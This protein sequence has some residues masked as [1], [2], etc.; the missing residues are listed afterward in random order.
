MIKLITFTSL[1]AAM[2]SSTALASGAGSIDEI[3]L[4]SGGVAEISRKPLVSSDGLVEIEVPLGQVDD[5][6]KSL[7]LK[8]GRGVINNISLAGPSPL[9]EVFR[10]LPFTPSDLSSISSLLSSIPGTSVTVSSGGKTVKGKI[11]GI[12]NAAGT[13]DNKLYLLTVL[14]QDEK[15]QTIKLSEDT[16]LGIDDPDIKTKL[17]NATQAMGKGSNDSS[18]LIRIAA[19]D[20]GDEDARLAYVVAAPIWKAAYRVLTQPEGKARLQAW[21]VV[22]NASGEDWKD[23]KLT[24]TSADPVTLKQRLHQIYWK[25]R[26]EIPVNVATVNSVEADTGNLNNRIRSSSLS[27]KDTAFESDEPVM[28]AARAPAPATS[29]YGG[30]SA[31]EPLDGATATATENDISASFALPGTFNLANGDSLSVPI[32]DA[33]IDAEM[34]SI[35]RS[36]SSSAHPVAAL[37]LKNVTDTSMPGGILTVYDSRTGYVGD[38]ELIGLPKGD[39]RIAAFATDRKVTITQEQQPTRQIIDIKVVDGVVR[40]SEKLRETTTYRIS[41]ALDA[42]RTIV[43]EH[44]TRD[45]WSFSSDAED[46]R[47][48]SYRRLKTSVKAGQ[49]KAVVAVD[50]RI[51][52]ERYGLIDID[53]ATLVSWSSTASDKAVADKFAK[54]ADAQRVKAEKERELQNSEEKLQFLQDEQE[55]IRQ[56]IAAV[57]ENSDLKSKYLAMLDK[58][59]T[60]IADVSKKREADKAEIDH[61]AQL[62]RE[63]IRNF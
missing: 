14:D 58:S 49:E 33:Q 45:G 63:Q 61:L 4:S 48:L 55:R 34:I 40:I 8:G 37:M 20:L 42:D 21:A 9:D 22:E 11:L 23:V 43:I 25:D 19:S 26:V 17:A 52:D 7:V 47:T 3:T 28:E 56:N 10:Q 36:A 54:L 53:P 46:G 12:E 32:A 15:I 31:N 62:L 44:P 5:V 18:R 51:Q 16:S 60:T 1:V 38:A 50:E 27:K 6:L 57:P 30:S 2:L 24:L 35:Y 59:E 41:G 29:G 39:T 13:E